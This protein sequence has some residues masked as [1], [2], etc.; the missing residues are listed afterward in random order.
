MK[1]PRPEARGLYHPYM[2]RTARWVIAVALCA[3][4]T[5]TAERPV[6]PVEPPKAVE[7]AAPSAPPAPAPEPAP[8]PLEASYLEGK[9]ILQAWGG[10]GRKLD[11]ARKIFM[12]LIEKNREYAPAY[13]GLA[14]VERAAGYRSG[15][16]YDPEALNRAW[17]LVHHALKVDPQLFDA[18]VTAAQIS[19]DRRDM[20]LARSSADQA[21]ELRPGDVRVKLLRAAIAQRDRQP[22]EMVR[23]ARDVIATSQDG[24]DRT[25]AYELLIGYHRMHSEM[26]AVD[27]AY[28]E[29]LK[30]QPESAWIHGNYA[31]FL[32]SRGSIDPA[33]AEAEHAIRILPY[34]IAVGTLAQAYFAKSNELWEAKRYD[35][36]AAYVE[37]VAAI[38]GDKDPG[39]SMELGQL[40]ERGAIRSH[41]PKL[42]QRA[43]RAYRKAL[44]L[45]PKN[46]EAKHAIDRLTAPR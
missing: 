13:V 45:D 34:P 32:L 33:I 7:T 36:S 31:E 9:K 41:D 12:G 16:T 25:Y 18:H 43:I 3:G 26:D 15:W 14:R 5:K 35:E 22:D 6:A 19:I 40:L 20:D 4:C 2:Y 8:D 42:R 28:K 27:A 46:E 30:L 1:D 37:K 10:D 23:I 21:E 17:K 44:E 29:Q 11:E 24:E 38:A 39:V